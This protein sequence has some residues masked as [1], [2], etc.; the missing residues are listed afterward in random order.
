MLQCVVVI[1]CTAGLSSV[2]CFCRAAECYCL[3]SLCCLVGWYLPLF[4]LLLSLLLWFTTTVPLG[5]CNVW[6][7][8]PIR[9]PTCVYFLKLLA[10]PATG[11]IFKHPIGTYF[12][13]G[14]GC[15]FLWIQGLSS[16]NVR[17][18]FCNC[19]A[20]WGQWRQLHI[21]ETNHCFG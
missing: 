16:L 19:A 2:C 11:S 8:E 1:L 20:P 10:S 21:C 5:V 15:W 17:F 4:C 14:Q 7:T 18:V 12:M 13:W 6:H 9:R 3:W